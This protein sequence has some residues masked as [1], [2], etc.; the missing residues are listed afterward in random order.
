MNE[1]INSL[2][3]NPKTKRAAAWDNE[4]NCFVVGLII[5]KSEADCPKYFAVS[6]GTEA[7]ANVMEYLCD[8]PGEA[9]D[10]FDV[11]HMV[12]D[13]TEDIDNLW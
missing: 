2:I 9:W 12:Y 5:N 13:V 7:F 1:R 10:T 8:E 4:D 6:K 11:P 3:I